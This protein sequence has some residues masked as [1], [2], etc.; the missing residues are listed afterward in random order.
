VCRRFTLDLGWPGVQA[1]WGGQCNSLI[2]KDVQRLSAIEGCL[3]VAPSVH[4]LVRTIGAAK[5]WEVYELR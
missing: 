3:S 5:K 2:Y 4:Y 1:L